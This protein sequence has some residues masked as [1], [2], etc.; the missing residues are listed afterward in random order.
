[1]ANVNS[2]AGAAGNLVAVALK[3]I[4]RTGTDGAQTQQT[5]L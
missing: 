2:A 1:M 5:D 3:Q 4:N